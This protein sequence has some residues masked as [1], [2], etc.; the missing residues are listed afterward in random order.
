MTTE[1]ESSTLNFS[2]DSESFLFILRASFIC[3]GI[4]DAWIEG[5][6]DF[7]NTSLEVNPATF[8]PIL[9]SRQLRNGRCK[10]D[11]NLLSNYSVLFL[12]AQM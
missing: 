1:L 6:T 2:L 4:G 5:T 10:Y 8:A 7:F 9:R 3:S 12:F 11:P